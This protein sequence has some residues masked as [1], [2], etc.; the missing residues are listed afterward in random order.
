MVP[1]HSARDAGVRISRYAL[2]DAALA[3]LDALGI[4]HDA[5]IAEAQLIVERKMLLSNPEQRRKLL[6]QMAALNLKET[7]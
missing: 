7:R 5:T 4:P 6:Q 1:L 3:L 2:S